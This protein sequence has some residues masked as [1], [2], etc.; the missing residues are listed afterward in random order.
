MNRKDEGKRKFVL[1]EQGEYFDLVTKPRV[2]KSSYSADWENGKAVGENTSLSTCF[3]ILK[4]ES[5]EDALNNLSLKRTQ[6]QQDLLSG[7]QSLNDDYL[8]NYMLNTEG[9]NS[10]LSTDDFIKPFDYSM[11]IATDSAGAFKGKKVDLVE[12]FNY[13]IGLTVKHIDAQP[14]RGFVRVTGTLPTGKAA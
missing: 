5:Y 10:L 9:R 2:I 4:L 3:K 12:T 6:Q 13:L 14:E 7:S 1:V 11:N 8:I